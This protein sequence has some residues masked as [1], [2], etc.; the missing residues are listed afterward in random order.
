MLSLSV[1][2]ATGKPRVQENLGWYWGAENGVCDVSPDSNGY[3]VY[4]NT[5]PQF[6]GRGKDPVQAVQDA[7]ATLDAH[8]ESLRKQRTELKLW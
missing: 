2:A 7:V 3:T 5:D 1:W 6:I 8:V 4:L